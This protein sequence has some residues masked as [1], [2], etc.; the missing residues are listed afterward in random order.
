MDDKVWYLVQAHLV[1]GRS[2]AELAAA[3]GVHRSWLYKLIGRYRAE[4]LAGLEARSRRPKRSPTAVASEIDDEIV[5]LRKQ[6]SEEGFDAGPATIHW[7]LAR[8][9]DQ[10]PST[11]TI[12]RILKRRGFIT[13]Q[14]RKRPQASLIRFAAELPNQCW[15]SDVTHWHLADGT[16]IEIINIIDDHSRYCIASIAFTVVKAT[17][18]VT[19]FTAARQRHGTPTA[20]LTDNGAVYTARY[21]NGSTAFE[22]E[23]AALGVTHKHSAPYHPQTC[24]KVERFH[25]TLKK[26]LTAQPAA[27]TLRA[28]QSN[29]DHF[30]THYNHHRPHRAIDRRT[31]HD[32]YT[33][34]LKATPN[35]ATTT[36]YRTRHDTIDPNGRVTLRYRGRLHH[37]GIGRHLTGT[38]IIMLIA[39]LD[40]RI[41][42]R[43]TGE[44]IRALTLNPNRDYQPQ[45]AKD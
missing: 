3:H 17:D 20:V 38:P 7:H 41:V 33:S 12:W 14:P 42:H 21:R 25:Q 19:V 16:N 13:A 11:S 23:L 15:Q 32:A 24:G 45:N 27:E 30:A 5:R 39:E 8:H 29:I 1:E 44:P 22:T 18:V 35:P 9:H 10:V 43:D 2:V 28:L 31:P 4:G 6:L 40:I 34:R 26:F 37:I 36:R